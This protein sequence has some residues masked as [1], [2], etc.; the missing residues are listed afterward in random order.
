MKRGTIILTPFPFTDLSGHKGR[1]A[2]IISSDSRQGSVV[3]IAFLSSVY[4]QKNL[5]PT[6][7]VL[8]TDHSD[9]SSSGLKTDS[10]L[11][12]DKL[13]TIDKKIIIGE[14]GALTKKTMEA[15]IQKLKIV[16]DMK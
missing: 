11:K 13:A 6:D 15:V 5:F 16:F 3:I 8:T 1:P 12:I 4:N 2:L 14:L 10:V 7:I 9:F